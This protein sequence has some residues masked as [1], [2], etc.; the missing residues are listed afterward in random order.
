MHICHAGHRLTHK[1]QKDT[2][3][4]QQIP[5]FVYGTLRTNQGNWSWALAGKTVQEMPAR[6]DHAI[7]HD[8][9]GGFPFVVRT[10]IPGRSVVGDLMFIDPAQYDDVVRDLDRLEGYQG[11]NSPTNMYDRHTVKVTT[12]DGTIYEANTYL[13]SPRLYQGRVRHLPVVESGDWVTH[14]HS[15]RSRYAN[16]GW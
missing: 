10:D 16:T 4:T 5:V 14:V 6:L 7:M 2:P 15:L 3:M 8:N 11:P 13:C 1:P 9:N 12:E